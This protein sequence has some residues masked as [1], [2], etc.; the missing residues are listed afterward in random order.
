MV[1][2]AAR[3]EEPEDAGPLFSLPPESRL[4][5]EFQEFSFNHPEVE[6]ELVKLA[7]K[8]K[9]KGR[10]SFGMKALWEV[11]RWTFWMESTDDVEPFKL[12]NNYPSR[13][14]RKIMRDYPDL[15]GFFQTRRLTS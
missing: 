10:A 9:A 7:R 1:E 2:R 8:A 15:R 11:M 6:T 13:Y 5:R 12:N 4:D 3:S 14:A